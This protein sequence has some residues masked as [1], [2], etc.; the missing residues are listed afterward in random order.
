MNMKTIF[1]TYLIVITLPSAVFA[2]NKSAQNPLIFADVPD[3]SMIRVGKN[4]YMSS[5]TMHM[6]P[7]LP[8]MKS[9]DLV[10]WKL[11]NY[12]YDTLANIDELNLTNGKSTYGRGS[13]ASSLQYHAG[14]YY[15][16][17]FAQTTGKTYIFRTKDIDQGHW[18]MSSFKPAYHDHTLFL[19]DDGKAYLVYG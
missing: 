9:T 2:Q 5:T 15:V 8:I 19:D 4:Y 1:L 10:N 16:T 13:W 11:I 6:S 14:V 17:T 3:M 7:G 12:A 18:K